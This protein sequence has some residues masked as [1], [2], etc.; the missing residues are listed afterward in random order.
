MSYSKPQPKIK[1]PSNQLLYVEG[2]FSAYEL[3]KSAQN[4]LAY[5]KLNF[6][7]DLGTEPEDVRVT[8]IPNP[9]CPYGYVWVRNL[10]TANMF[11]GLNPDG[12]SRDI[13]TKDHRW[14]SPDQNMSN[15]IEGF[16][17]AVNTLLSK[18]LW[19]NL[20]GSLPVLD[21][22][23]G[24][25]F[26]K[27]QVGFLRDYILRTGNTLDIS[28]IAQKITDFLDLY[29]N[30]SSWGDQDEYEREIH[31]LL[32][33]MEKILS[34]YICPTI[35]RKQKP[36]LPLT[37]NIQGKP[38]TI[39][40]QSAYAHQAAPDRDSS[41]L[42]AWDVPN[43]VTEEMIYDH[44]KVFSR[45][46]KEA[47]VFVNGQV[48]KGHYPFVYRGTGDRANTVYVKFE[49]HSGDGLFAQ[50]VSSKYVVSKKVTLS[51]NFIKLKQ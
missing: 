38:K 20:K 31:S 33:R 34:N 39:T 12:T 32:D 24:V 42:A 19:M 47:S 7:G 8:T 5:G 30:T 28:D 17:E 22:I 43:W 45:N 51:F 1:V 27:D 2:N 49:A 3:F 15:L 48:M 18:N 16:Q 10:N 40:P 36:L 46:N 25:E 50:L 6:D 4:S 35:V 23:K 9:R 21:H 44:F 26:E 13:S 37:V 11:L 14:R 29:D 41:T